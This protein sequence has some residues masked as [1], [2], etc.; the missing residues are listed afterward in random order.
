MPLGNLLQTGGFQTAIEET[1]NTRQC[2][3]NS[4]A[5]HANRQ[6]ELARDS[7]RCRKTYEILTSKLRALAGCT[8]CDCWLGRPATRCEYFEM[9]HA[10]TDL[11]RQ[12]CNAA[13]RPRLPRT[14]K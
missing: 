11:V 5:K 1:G 4:L 14:Q 9:S 13:V 6:R 12:A 7:V 10:V 2:Q 8:A 3:P